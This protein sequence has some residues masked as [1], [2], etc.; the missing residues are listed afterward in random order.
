LA[1]LSVQKTLSSGQTM[2]RSKFP[3]ARL[4]ETHKR[5]N[6]PLLLR[7]V[8]EDL[9]RRRAEH[10]EGDIASLEELSLHQQEIEKYKR[11]AGHLT[12]P[13][14]SVTVFVVC[15][16]EHLDRWCRNLKI[17]YLQNNLIPRIGR[18]FAALSS[19]T[20]SLSFV[21]LIFPIL[22]WNF[23]LCCSFS[24]S[25]FYSILKRMLVA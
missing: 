11:P 7:A 14:G 24:F 25:F 6:R 3:A 15:R 12:A 1:P 21:S 8:T 23:V 5:V 19:P 17:L 18:R 20:I 2:P 16:I 4:A 13:S 10:N 9:V 22:K